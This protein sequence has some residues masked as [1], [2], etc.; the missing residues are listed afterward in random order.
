[1]AG[2]VV[3]IQNGNTSNPR[4]HPEPTP[5]R[6]V[7]TAPDSGNGDHHRIRTGE[8][9]RR[10]RKPPGRNPCRHW[11]PWTCV[12]SG[13][14]HLHEVPRSVQAPTELVDRKR[15]KRG[16][17]TIGSEPQSERQGPLCIQRPDPPTRQ[18]RASGSMRELADSTRIE[19]FMRELGRA[20]R[21]DSHAYLTGGAT[22]VLHGW[23]ATTPRETHPR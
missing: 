15:V 12:G 10:S 18:L 22:A 11:P 3:F 4:P 17:T 14:G 23:R 6:R 7:R 5:D 9:Q 1:M 20:A 16:E 21:A 2:M 8:C 13:Q 19:L